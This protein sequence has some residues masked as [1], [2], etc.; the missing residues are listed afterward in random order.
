[1]SPQACDPD[2]PGLRE[3]KKLATR[4]ALQR[5]ALALA[6]ERGPDVTVEEICAA[7][8]LS[9]RTFFNYFSSKEEAIVGG[10]PAVPSDEVLATFE[11][12]G[13]SGEV[14]AD[15]SDALGPHL[16]DTLP[17]LREMHLR[18]QV[19]EQHPELAARFM[20]GF[21]RI[22]QRL[23]EAVARRS[24]TDTH[25]LHAQLVAS[26]ASAAMHL[27]VRRWIHSGGEPPVETHVH[28]V[29]AELPTSLQTH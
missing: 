9:P 7:V 12:G 4:R 1:M 19:I 20:G 3:R 26:V 5:A 11:A 10:S 21:M 22:E 18:R 29:F 28:T 14:W 16:R 15:L 24:A 2:H 17:S 13:P 25:D 8:D 23:V 27:S 6:A